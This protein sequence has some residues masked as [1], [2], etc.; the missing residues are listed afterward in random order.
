MSIEYVNKMEWV[1][2]LH[3]A[4]L[5][6]VFDRISTIAPKKPS[7][8]IVKAIIEEY[9]AAAGIRE[10]VPKFNPKVTMESAIAALLKKNK[11]TKGG[12]EA[13]G[14]LAL[15]L[16]KP[17]KLATLTKQVTKLELESIRIL[18]GADLLTFQAAAAVARHSAQ[19][20]APKKDG[21]DGQPTNYPQFSIDW[22]EVLAADCIG[23]FEGGPLGA[24]VF[25]LADALVQLD[26]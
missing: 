13:L 2:L 22:G 10:A 23:F 18:D 12:A 5:R 4:S 20:W 17:P 8:N 9:F 16:S 3:N 26:R 6:Y 21:G 1:G 24:A 7:K 14:K 15:L 19:L 11:V 25:S